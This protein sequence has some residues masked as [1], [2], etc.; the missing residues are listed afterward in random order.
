[1]VFISH[2]SNKA[3]AKKKKKHWSEKNTCYWFSLLYSQLNFSYF[4]VKCKT[5]TVAI[6]STRAKTVAAYGKLCG[7]LTCMHPAGGLDA[8]ILHPLSPAQ[9]S[10]LFLLVKFPLKK[11]ELPALWSVLGDP[12][13]S[14]CVF[15]QCRALLKFNPGPSKR[16]RQD[17]WH[18]R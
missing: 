3:K 6:S 15:L 9:F 18:L 10:R 16:D 12:N 7:V 5:S 8:L 11:A 2:L 17:S 14:A 13:H 4:M 1:M